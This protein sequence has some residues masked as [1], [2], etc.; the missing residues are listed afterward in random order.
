MSYNSFDGVTFGSANKLRVFL[1]FAF[2]CTWLIL[3]NK[4]LICIF[5]LVHT[6]TDGKSLRQETSFGVSNTWSK[7]GV[8]WSCFREVWARHSNI[9]CAAW[10][11]L[12]TPIGCAFDKNCTIRF[13]DNAPTTHSITCR[14]QYFPSAWLLPLH[15]KCGWPS[16]ELGL[17][18]GLDCYSPFFRRPLPWLG[19]LG[20]GLPV[21]CTCP[22]VCACASAEK[23]K[24]TSP[25]SVSTAHTNPAHLF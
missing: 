16:G 7:A 5:I 9:A 6:C 13:E 24:K 11:R 23:Q 15:F 1:K 4:L 25:W 10:G 3:K 19:C 8:I 14:V 12:V 2:R 17:W 18:S 22:C 20:P 21:P